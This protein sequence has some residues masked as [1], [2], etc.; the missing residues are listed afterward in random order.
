[1]EK[2]LLVGSIFIVVLSILMQVYQKYWMPEWLA[3]VAVFFAIIW[4]GYHDH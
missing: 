4:R 3:L 2:I 1:M